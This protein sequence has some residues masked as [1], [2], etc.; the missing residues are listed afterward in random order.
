VDPLAV[1]VHRYREFLFGGFLPD[2]VLIQKL[3]D[4]KRFRD[5]VGGARGRL[6]LVVFQNRVTYGDALVADVSPG[7]VAGGR[8][9]LSDYVLTLMTKRTP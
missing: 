8:D 2:H 7:I 4:F 5:L 6:D 9:E 1:V 3:F